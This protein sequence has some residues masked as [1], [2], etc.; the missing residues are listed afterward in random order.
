L[1]I[2]ITPAMRRA[3]NASS[4]ARVLALNRQRCEREREL[5]KTCE[6][7]I[8]LS[9]IREIEQKFQKLHEKRE[10]LHK[11]NFKCFDGGLVNV[12]SLVYLSYTFCVYFVFVL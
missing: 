3:F 4:L 6:R 7:K 12:A 11:E 9:Q 2:Q 1:E 8:K 5:E 10:S